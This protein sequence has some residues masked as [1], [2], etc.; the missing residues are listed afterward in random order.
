MRLGAFFYLPQH[1]SSSSGNSSVSVFG[2]SN[3]H[4]KGMPKF[5]YSNNGMNS[6][7]ANVDLQSMLKE[8][9]TTVWQEI[10]KRGSEEWNFI[11]SAAPHIGCS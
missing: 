3:K 4:G 10:S 7:G 9:V 2:L 8:V 5:V 1:E 6:R 11:P